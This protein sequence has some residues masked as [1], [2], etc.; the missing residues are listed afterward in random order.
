MPTPTR[1]GRSVAL[2]TRTDV[3]KALLKKLEQSL[4]DK[5]DAK[6]LHFEAYTAKEIAAKYPTLK[7]HKAGLLIPYFDAQGRRTKFWRYRLLESNLTGFEALTD[8][9]PVRYLQ[10]P[11]TLNEL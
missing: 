6:L 10:P 1:A 8:K 2:S 4:L 9:K 11:Q 7:Y 5:N 3:Q